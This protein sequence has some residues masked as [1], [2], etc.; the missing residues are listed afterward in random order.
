MRAALPVTATAAVNGDR[1]AHTQVIPSLE[2]QTEQRLPDRPVL[3]TLDQLRIHQT[4]EHRSDSLAD[5][6]C[7][8]CAGF[9]ARGRAA[10]TRVFSAK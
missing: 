9:G 6:F 3:V 5:Y 2:K 7:A 1:V 4:R 8:A 10:T